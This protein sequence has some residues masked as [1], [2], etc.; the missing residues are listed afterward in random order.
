MNDCPRAVR[1]TDPRKTLP[2]APAGVLKE[3]VAAPDAFREVPRSFLPAVLAEH[4][5][6]E[7][8]IALPAAVTATLA[9]TK[10]PARGLVGKTRAAL[11]RTAAGGGEGGGGAALVTRN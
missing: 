7:G 5:T 10:P 11:A 3:Q 4:A 2:L 6:A 9:V 8:L 1:R